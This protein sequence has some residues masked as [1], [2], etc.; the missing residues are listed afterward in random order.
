MQAGDLVYRWRTLME[1]DGGSVV[2]G[3][4][5]AAAHGVGRGL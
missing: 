3:W 4:D 1:D 5:E 2:A